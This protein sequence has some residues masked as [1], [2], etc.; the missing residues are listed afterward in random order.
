MEESKERFEIKKKPKKL[1]I[2]SKQ[3]I[4]KNHLEKLYDLMHKNKNL[5]ID[6]EH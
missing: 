5:I 1:I 2:R 3:P 4:D 6:P